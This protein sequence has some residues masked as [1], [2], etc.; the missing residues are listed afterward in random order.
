MCIALDIL[1]FGGTVSCSVLVRSSVLW[2]SW[3]AGQLQS[4][5]PGSYRDSRHSRPGFCLKSQTQ[6]YGWW[7]P[8]SQDAALQS[9][10]DLDFFLPRS[11]AQEQ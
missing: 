2:K 10:S 1:V 11:L 7:S 9:A 3:V 4:S 5:R 8:P 6:R